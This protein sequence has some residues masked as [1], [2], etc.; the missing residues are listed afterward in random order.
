M[1]R[2]KIT[3]QEYSDKDSF[4]DQIDENADIRFETFKITV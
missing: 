4:E 2:V 1:Q 3:G